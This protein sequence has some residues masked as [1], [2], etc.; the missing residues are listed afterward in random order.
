MRFKPNTDYVLHGLI[1]VMVAVVTCWI[2]LAY[3]ESL[4]QPTEP[5][6]CAQPTLV[7]IKETVNVNT[8]PST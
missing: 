8:K 3:T 6:T 2:T 1:Y 4:N 7:V 5:V